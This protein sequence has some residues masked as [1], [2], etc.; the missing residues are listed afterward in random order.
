MCCVKQFSSPCTCDCT[1]HAIADVKLINFKL[2]DKSSIHKNTMY[3]AITNNYYFSKCQTRLT[4]PMSLWNSSFA[5]LL[6]VQ[7]C[8]IN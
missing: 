4:I 8:W 5:I 3:R 7:M 2:N 1:C 6:Y